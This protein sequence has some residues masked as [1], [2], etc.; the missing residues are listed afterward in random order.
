MSKIHR[1]V[2]EGNAS[3][4]LS[5]IAKTPEALDKILSKA[6]PDQPLHLAAWQNESEIAR[7]LIDKGADIN[8]RGD[9]NRAP[10]HYAAQHGSIDVAKI[11]VDSGADLNLQDAGGFTSLISALRGRQPSC[12][13]VAQLLRSAGA[14]ADLNS[15]VS[16]GEINAVC[17]SSNKDTNLD[18][19]IEP[20]SLIEDF[21]I[22]VEGETIDSGLYAPDERQE[23]IVNFYKGMLLCLL[24]L[25]AEINALGSTGYPGLFTAVQS[26]IPSLVRLLLENGADVNYRLNPHGHSINAMSLTSGDEGKEVRKILN[27]Y[28]FKKA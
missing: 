22:M 13:K 27:E 6:Q 10:L 25:G 5:I 26:N 11:L 23:A 28:G 14:F 17:D 24:K 7:I 4:V 21:V 8:A 3:G 1:F 15:L 19:A 18:A 2:E 9:N 12:L 16:M 20:D